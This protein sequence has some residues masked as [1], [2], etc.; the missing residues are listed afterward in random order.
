VFAIPKHQVLKS[1][2]EREQTLPPL[3]LNFFIQF[4]RH[5][6]GSGPHEPVFKII[7]YA[8]L[9]VFDELLQHILQPLERAVLDDG[10]ESQAALLLMY[11]NLLHHWTAGLR[12]DTSI[13]S[14]A[15]SS[16]SAM[17]RHVNNLCLALLQTK[18]TLLT[19]STIMEFYEQNCRLITD[20]SLIRE[21]RIEL[22]PPL[23]IYTLFFSNSLS[24]L[25][26]LCDILTSYKKGFEMAM[27]TRSRRGDS[28]G[29]DTP[30]YDRAYVALYNGFLMDICNCFWRTRAFSDADPE[31]QGCLVPRSTISALTLY[32]PSVESTFSLASLLS[33]SHSPL[34][35]LQSIR[36]VRRLEDAELENDDSIRSRHAGPVTQN[37]LVKLAA[38]GGIRLSWQDYRIGVLDFLNSQGHPG[39]G[40]LL[41]NTMKVL[42]LSQGS[43]RSS[44]AFSSQ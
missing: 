9:H 10:P 1:D 24:T 36:T 44:Q 32:V 6:D 31:T 20:D 29:V 17:T 27:L 35:C 7:A 12:A 23:L 13:P 4:F 18:P 39:V 14:H 40:E 21:M 30:S 22:P 43:R 34:L 11:T 8:P 41:M 5:W 28:Q 25:S 16:V 3:L 38:S 26:R 33:L 15:S 37:S 42:R 19:E 2:K